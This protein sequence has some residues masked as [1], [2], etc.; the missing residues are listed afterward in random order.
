LAN[1]GQ[2]LEADLK[3][4]KAAIEPGELYFAGSQEGNDGVCEGHNAAVAIVNRLT[5][6]LVYQSGQLEVD[7]TRR[8]L[9][10]RGIPVPI[11]GRAFE[12]IEVLVKAAGNVVTKDDLM[13]SV[14]PGAIVEESTLWVHI[15]AVRKALGAERGK[16]KTISRRGYQLHGSWR[17]AGAMVPIGEIDSREPVAP[18]PRAF[19]HNLPAPG[20]SLIGRQ[21]A[22]HELQDLL[23]A[24]RMVT[25]TGPGGIGKSRL[26]LE[27]ARHALAQPRGDVW[28]VEL[29]SLSDPNLVPSTVARSLGLRIGI[30][31][32]SPELLAR[33]IGQRTLLLLLDNCEHI[34]DAVARLVEAIV[35]ICPHVTILATSRE[36]LRID[37]EYVYDVL[38]L[39]VPNEADPTRDILKS[40]AVQLFV[41]RTAAIHSA[42]SPDGANLRDVA[43]ICQRLDGIP[44]A[45]EFAAARAAAL[46]VSQVHSLLDDRFNLLTAGRRTTLARHRTLRA[47]LDWSYDLL[48]ISEQRLL[49]HL[50]IFPAGFTLEAARAAMRDTGRQAT[51]I[52]GLANLVGKSLVILDE[53][54]PGGRWR[55]LETIRAYGLDKLR[56]NNELEE[57]LR[58]QAEFFRDFLVPPGAASYPEPDP[59]VRLRYGREIDNIRAALDWCFSPSGDASIGTVITAAF[60]PVWHHLALQLECRRRTEEALSS[61]N[62]ESQ[63]DAPIRMALYINL[64]ITLNHTGGR[65]DQALE[66]L[67]KGLGIAE[68][69]NDTISQMYAL[70]A[71]WVTYGYKGQFRAA[72]PFA[73]KF[74]RLA[75]EGD[76]PA[77]GYL[78]DRLMG[79]SMHYRGKQPQA[80][81]HLDRVADQYRRSLERPQSAWFGYNLSDF[82]QSTV[83]RVLCMEGF[84]DQAR[85]LAQDCVDRA[86]LANQKLGLCF[87]LY[88]AACPIALMIDDLDAASRHIGLLVEAAAEQD[89]PY[90]KAVARCLEG[91]LLVKRGSFSAGIT[92]LR[93]SLKVCDGFGG[94]SRYPMYLGAIAKALSE[95]GL[96][97][98][99]R[100]TLD[101]ALTRAD[102]DGEEWCIPDLLRS[103]GELALQESKP[104][105]LLEAEGYFHRAYTLARE[106]GARLW[107][108]RCALHLARLH[109]VQNRVEDA[110]Q[111]LDPVYGQFVEGFDAADLRAAKLMLE[112]LSAETTNAR[113]QR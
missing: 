88:E 32:L 29:A 42:F 10:V 43:G 89:L 81:K 57:A 46:G 68:T 38:P 74:F 71:L 28:L 25:L 109:V 24:Y 20:T 64:G 94:T 93:S 62:D 65:S 95:L 72:E 55:I 73:E 101:L 12:I 15:S 52:D 60:S 7:M 105:S 2:I 70:W 5:P 97:K 79:T 63:D 67:T 106:Q 86:Q 26:A 85:N 16:L 40:S 37:G 22:M 6:K 23:S 59:E 102:R 103:K 31:D 113:L 36:V 75:T 111:I 78:A 83:A 9:R 80:R 8:E 66:M 58:Q 21:S 39:D 44:L 76:D 51:V 1:G 50:S 54:A 100:D 96:M 56:E 18:A 108:L 35:Q 34:I 4:P 98:E 45:I 61:L 49:R 82:A 11:G 110:R 90:W 41:E 87:T 13:Q 112:S 27:A 99:A 47:A 19:S 3:S 33:A 107:E 91:V 17:T 84:L 69:L 77:R 48:T 14:W 53:S 104:S 30:A 92:A